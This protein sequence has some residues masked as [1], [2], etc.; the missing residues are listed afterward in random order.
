MLFI[1]VAS[2]LNPSFGGY[3]QGLLFPCT[4]INLSLGV[5]SVFLL[6]ML[7]VLCRTISTTALAF[8]SSAQTNAAH[9]T[10][11]ERTW[12]TI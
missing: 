1:S 9:P 12:L 6:V 5:Q 10:L 3:F 2:F 8:P 4:A 7:S 11:P